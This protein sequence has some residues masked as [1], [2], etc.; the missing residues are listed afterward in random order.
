MCTKNQYYF[1]CAVC[2][3]CCCWCFYSCMR[4]PFMIFITPSTLCPK[5]F[6]KRILTQMNT[7]FMYQHYQHWT[8][9]IS[10]SFSQ[11]APSSS[12]KLLMSFICIVHNFMSEC[13][14]RIY[15][16]LVLFYIAFIRLYTTYSAWL[17]KMYV[18][19]Y[20]WMYNI[21]TFFFLFNVLSTLHTS[22]SA[23]YFQINLI[24]WRQLEELTR[25]F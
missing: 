16:I 20:F 7:F 5:C 4:F 17:Q 22:V 8:R 11:F 13:T 24:A 15:Y 10:L 18:V 23:V 12:A 2:I 25:I 19:Q 1:V 3:L 9:F 6:I 14:L 21:H